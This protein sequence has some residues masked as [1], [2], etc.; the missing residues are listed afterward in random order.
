MERKCADITRDA[1]RKRV[2]MFSWIQNLWSTPAREQV[3]VIEQRA[4]SIEERLERILSRS[5]GAKNQSETEFAE[6]VED[7]DV[8]LQILESAMN[9]LDNRDLDERIKRLRTRLR[10]IR[11]RATNARAA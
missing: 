1:S 5:R 3:L 2:I 4:P 10:T 7:I 8:V 6:L 11:T 9:I